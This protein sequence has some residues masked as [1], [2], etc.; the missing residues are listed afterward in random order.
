M[1]VTVGTL[2]ALT[3]AVA[4]ASGQPPRERAAQLKAPVALPASE[5]PNGARGAEPSAVLGGGTP[6]DRRAPQTGPAWLTGADPNLLPAGGAAPKGAGANPFPLAP[7]DEPSFRERVKNALPSFGTKDA[8]P[9]PNPLPEQVTS[10]K[11]APKPTAEPIQPTAATAFKAVSGT[12]APV[13]AGPPAYRWYGWGTVTPGANP[14]APAGQ[15]PRASAAWYSVTGATPGAFPVPVSNTGQ[16]MPGVEPPTYGL[17]RSP[18]PV[19]PS[20]PL[21]P[22]AGSVSE[23][24]VPPA[25]PQP[26]PKFAPPAPSAF[27]PPPAFIPPTL[28]APPSAPA[29]VPTL[30]PPPIHVPTIA[31]PPGPKAVAVAVAPPVVPPVPLPKPA[32]VAPPDAGALLIPSVEP[33]APVVPA[34]REAVAAP[35]TKPEA[36]PDVKAEPEPTGP[37]PLPTT[38]TV[39]DEAHWNRAAHP[40][41]PQP[42]QW[43]PANGAAPLPTRAPNEPA[44][45]PGTTNPPPVVRGQIN[46]TRADPIAELV[47]QL[48]AGRADGVE[49]RYVGTKKLVVCFEVRGKPSAEKLVADISAR[50]ELTA[51]QIDFCVVVK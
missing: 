28:P 14:A 23:A 40:A 27:A 20:A 19:A 26:E 36:K 8:P 31:Q 48:C 15:Y 25:R 33:A 6:V 45:K 4:V 38:A 46:E 17:T 30:P 37:R 43:V 11:P 49:V 10:K 16:P 21:A 47:K 34:A 12:G 18:A 7:K 22:I 50:P 13:F 39:R 35:E 51:Y 3:L 9:P 41:P 24:F 5:V 32:D 1:R 2:G 42:G 29:L 44:W